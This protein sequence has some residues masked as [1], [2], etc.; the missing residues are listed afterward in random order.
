MPIPDRP[1]QSDTD[2][3]DL[4][5]VLAVIERIEIELEKIAGRLGSVAGQRDRIRLKAEQAHLLKLLKQ[6]RRKPPEAGLAMPAVSPKGPLPQQGGAEAPL[7]FGEDDLSADQ[8][9]SAF[10]QAARS[11]SSASLARRAST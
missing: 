8:R 5:A 4:R 6:L 1:D 10:A 7:D 3:R 9:R 2:P 11:T